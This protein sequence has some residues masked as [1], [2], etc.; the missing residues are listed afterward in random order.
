MSFILGGA[1]MGGGNALQEWAQAEREAAAAELARKDRQAERQQERDWQLEDQRTERNWQLED[2]ARGDKKAADARRRRA[3]VYE[4]LFGTESGGNF[5]AANDEG[6]MGRSQ[7]GDER[8]ADYTRAKGG[9]PLTASDIKV[10]KGDSDAVKQQKIKLQKDIEK[11]HFADIN[12][13]IDSND[14]TRFEGQ[15]IGGVEMTRSG[16]IAMAHLGGS[17]GMKRFLESGGKYDPEDSNGTSLSDYA[18]THGGLS[19]DMAGVWDLISDEDVPSSIRETVFE[20]ATGIDTATEKAKDKKPVSLQTAERDD[21]ANVIGQKVGGITM[22]WDELLSDPDLGRYA[23]DILIKAGE[24]KD[25]GDMTTPEIAAVIADMIKVTEEGGKKGGLFGIGREAPTRSVSFGE[26]LG[27]AVGTGSDRS[28]SASRTSGSTAN[29]AQ[30]TS[31][32]VAS[33][34]ARAKQ[35]LL[36]NPDLADQFDEKY[37]RGAAAAILGG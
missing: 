23:N 26:A 22:D 24:L 5:G 6:Y 10:N 29:Q 17:G 18:R 37:G 19:T 30:G 16:M 31:L 11:W 27:E 36:D 1:L 3:N 35:A 34:P 25:R 14:L 28:A 12:S 15:T 9:A 8:L 32:D 33:I 21:I 7:F 2:E 20:K 4:S 13:F